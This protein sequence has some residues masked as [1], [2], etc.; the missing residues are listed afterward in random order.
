MSWYNSERTSNYL[1]QAMFVCVVL[2]LMVSV[3]KAIQEIKSAALIK[4][5]K[6][7][8]KVPFDRAILYALIAAEQNY[9]FKKRLLPRVH[10]DDYYTLILNTAKRLA[11][12][13]SGRVTLPG[14]KQVAGPDTTKKE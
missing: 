10:E 2:M 7:L 9:Q 6:F 4:Q 12:A 11:M 3:G 8:A 1:I 13:D 14:L 5:E